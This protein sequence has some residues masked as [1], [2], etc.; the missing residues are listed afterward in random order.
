MAK[1]ED[2]FSADPAPALGVAARGYID[3]ARIDAVNGE[4]TYPSL[5]KL[6][7]VMDK[8][9]IPC[10]RKSLERLV[11]RQAVRQ[12]QAPIRR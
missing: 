9:G 10:D 3:Q 11:K 5:Q 4:L 2:V 12:V 1:L 7:H 6:R 8:R